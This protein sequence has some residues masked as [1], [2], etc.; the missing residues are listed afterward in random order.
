MEKYTTGEVGASPGAGRPSLLAVNPG[1]PAASA[2]RR[3]RLLGG[4]DKLDAPSR[5]TF[6][7]LCETIAHAGGEARAERDELRGLVERVYSA[8]GLA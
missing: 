4:F 7:E 6:L 2:A 3:A 8:A 5:A 1:N